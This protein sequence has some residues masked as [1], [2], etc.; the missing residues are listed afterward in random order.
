MS[1]FKATVDARE[2]APRDKH[3]VIISTFES[4]NSGESMLLV[5]DHEPR[6][7]FYQFQIEYTDQFKWEYLEEGPE[8]WHVRIIKI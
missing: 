1:E 5:N 4:L 7:L 3:R 2:Y 6:P 8:V